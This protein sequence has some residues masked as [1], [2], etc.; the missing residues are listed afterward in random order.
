MPI[1]W[2][3]AIIAEVNARSSASVSTSAMKLRSILTRQ[4]EPGAGVTGGK[5]RAEVIQPDSVCTLAKIGQRA[6]CQHVVMQ[7]TALG[8]FQAEQG[9]VP[10]PDWVRCVN[11]DF[12]KP[13]LQ[14]FWRPETFHTDPDTWQP[15]LSSQLHPG[16]PASVS[17]RPVHQSG[18]GFGGRDKAFWRNSP[19]SGM[20]TSEAGARRRRGDRNPLP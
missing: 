16:R 12:I 18:A 3:I 15:G 5:P 4:P 8:Q 19:N 20:G 13:T 17:W 6:G 1:E 7:Q 10:T 14:Q 2:A 9:R 11:D